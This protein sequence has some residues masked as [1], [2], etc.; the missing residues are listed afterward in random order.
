MQEETMTQDRFAGM[1]GLL[2]GKITS[3]LKFQ[4]FDVAQGAVLFDEIDVL[5]LMDAGS[6]ALDLADEHDGAA[7]R[8]TFSQLLAHLPQK[9][10]LF[11]C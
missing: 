6:P 1:L 11:G 2:R 10:T 8:A 7:K 4:S 9:W 5:P 3:R